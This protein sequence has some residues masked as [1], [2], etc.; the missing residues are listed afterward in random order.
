MDD[1]KLSKF[2]SGGRYIQA[3][4]GLRCFRFIPKVIACIS[5][6]RWKLRRYLEGISVLKN[7]SNPPFLL[8]TS[9]RKG[10]LIPGKINRLSGNEESSFVLAI[11]N[12][13]KLLSIKWEIL[14]NLFR[15]EFILRYLNKIHLKW[16]YLY[17]IFLSSLI[18][19]MLLC[20]GKLLPVAQ[21][22]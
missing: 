5:P 15:I 18:I 7:T 9:N 8:V 16:L 3:I 6:V 14:E 11:A 4:S 13:S 17:N 21:T 1:K 22:Q 19:Q 20:S 10:S 12:M 2:W